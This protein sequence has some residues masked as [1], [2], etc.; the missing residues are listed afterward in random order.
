A[1][2]RLQ[3][4][5]ACPNSVPPQPTAGFV[6]PPQCGSSPVSAGSAHRLGR[7]HFLGG[8]A[9]R[10]G[11]GEP[12]AVLRPPQRKKC[13]PEE[14][15]KFYSGGLTARPGRKGR[16]GPKAAS[17]AQ[18]QELVR[19]KVNRAAGRYTGKPEP[20]LLAK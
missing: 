1:C 17:P 10:G 8:A 7:P 11:K 12:S 3:P 5:P 6:H 16:P 19:G 15:H 18:T 4:L 9:A 13:P 2:E 20:A 14:T